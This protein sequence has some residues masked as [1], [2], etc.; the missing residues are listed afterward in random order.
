MGDESP[1]LPFEIVSKSDDGP[2]WDGRPLERRESVPG[3]KG[4]G[5]AG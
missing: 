2:N 3:E 5:E 1:K 4:N